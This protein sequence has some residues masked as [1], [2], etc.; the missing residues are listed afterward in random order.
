[1]RTISGYADCP[2]CNED[3]NLCLEVDSKIAR[4]I[5]RHPRHGTPPDWCPLRKGDITVR[6]E[7][8]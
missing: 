7:S 6:L 3:W 4:T 2:F 5:P 8:G 1:M